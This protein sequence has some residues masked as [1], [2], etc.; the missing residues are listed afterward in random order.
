MAVSPGS[1]I[2]G[3]W[4]CRGHH[5]PMVYGGRSAWKGPP[6]DASAPPHD[7]DARPCTG[8]AAAGPCRCDDTGCQA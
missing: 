5:G 1:F 7:P 4:F 6:L 2:S 3:A 8:P